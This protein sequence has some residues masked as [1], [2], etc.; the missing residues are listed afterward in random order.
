MLHE[1]KVLARYWDAIADGSKTFEVRRN[2]RAFQVGDILELKKMDDDGRFYEHDP[3]SS[4]HVKTIR[5]RITYLFQGGRFG[6]E[7]GYCVLGL[8]EP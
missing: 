3:P 6:I 5:K 7:A 4:S 2:D 8:G 1:L